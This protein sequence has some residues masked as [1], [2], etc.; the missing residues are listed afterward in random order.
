[1]LTP[2]CIVAVF[3]AAGAFVA[4]RSKWLKNHQVILGIY[5]GVMSIIVS[6]IS[7]KFPDPHIFAGLIDTPSMIAGFFFGAVPA[8][9]AGLIGAVGHG[10]PVLFGAGHPH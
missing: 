4:D 7:S 1:M 3:M 10:I 5:F 9:I 2:V 8:L 6:F